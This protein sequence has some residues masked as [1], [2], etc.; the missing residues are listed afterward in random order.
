[1]SFREVEFVEVYKDFS[2]GTTHSRYKVDA[3][4]AVLHYNAWTCL[5]Y[6]TRIGTPTEISPMT[7]DNMPAELMHLY[8]QALSK[9]KPQHPVEVF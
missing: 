7:V 8:K 3:T 9:L 2:G 1:M 5:W 4:G 6:Q